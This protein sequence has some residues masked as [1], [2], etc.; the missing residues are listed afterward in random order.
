MILQIIIHIMEQ[1]FAT[2]VELSSGKILTLSEGSVEHPLPINV[3][4][5]PHRK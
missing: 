5:K 2:L 4:F 3:D 1:K